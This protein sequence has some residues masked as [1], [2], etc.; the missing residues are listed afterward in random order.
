MLQSIRWNN[1]MKLKEAFDFFKKR[2]M[3]ENRPNQVWST[4]STHIIIIP[5]HITPLN[6]NP[7]KDIRTVYLLL[8]HDNILFVNLV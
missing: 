5:K 8:Q 6:K 7:M 4:D 2:G 1:Y 3:K